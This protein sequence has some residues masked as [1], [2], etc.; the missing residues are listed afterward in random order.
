MKKRVFCVVDA[1]AALVCGTGVLLILLISKSAAAQEVYR[2]KAPDGRVL[3]SDAPC[4]SASKAERMV[5]TPNSLDHG[6]AREQQL[7]IENQRLK[8]QIRTQQA[9]QI[10]PPSPAEPPKRAE[11]IDSIECQKARRDYEVTAN[12]SSS[13]KR[14]I[15]AKRAAMYGIC[16]IREPDRTDVRINNEVNI[17]TPTYRR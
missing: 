9:L 16:G 2:C 1:R 17:G 8:E 7:L 3:F 4:P 10:P 12:S 13:K 15:E 11:R 6:G 14:V 5:V